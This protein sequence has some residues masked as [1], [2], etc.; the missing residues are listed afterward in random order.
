M[1]DR[2]AARVMESDGGEVVATASA[3]K[4]GAV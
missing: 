1:S 4:P 3:T 2:L